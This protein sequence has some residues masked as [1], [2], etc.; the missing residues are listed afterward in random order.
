[1]VLVAL[2]PTIPLFSIFICYLK[3]LYTI[4][5]HIH[6][7]PPNI[8]QINFFFLPNELLVLIYFFF[9]LSCPRFDA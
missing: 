8:S 7:P 2:I 6:L 5:I 9:N 4:L 1:M 3:I